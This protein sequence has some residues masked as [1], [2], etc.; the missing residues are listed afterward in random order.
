MKQ[1]LTALYG[2]HFA[3]VMMSVY[4]NIYLAYLPTF[5]YIWIIMRKLL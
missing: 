1:F 3:R 5:I 2:G 4:I